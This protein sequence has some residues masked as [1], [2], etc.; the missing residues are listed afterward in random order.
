MKI[1]QANQTNRSAIIELL[2]NE[3]LPVDD[4]PG[5][6]DHFFIAVS[7]SDIIGVI[8]LEH[9]PPFG[10]LRSMVVRKDH[11]NKKVATI[12]VETLEKHA[13]DLKVEFIY[14]LTETASTYF[15]K[16]NYQTVERTEVPD[17]IKQSTEFS[18]VCPVSAIVMKKTL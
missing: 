14:L 1:I 6:L 12:L 11:Q 16:K 8:G 5:N 4:L 15:E 7:D 18:S 9:Y 17:E 13:A 2:K 3:K 10:L